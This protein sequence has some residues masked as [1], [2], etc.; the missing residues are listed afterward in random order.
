[1]ATLASVKKH[2]YWVGL[3]MLSALIAA[4]VL[5]GPP[6]SAASSSSAK[7]WSLQTGSRRKC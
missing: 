2:S 4:A 1:M 3:A 5:L 6:R 7:P